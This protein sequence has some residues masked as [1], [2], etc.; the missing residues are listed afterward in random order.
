MKYSTH[1]PRPTCLSPPSVRLLIRAQ[2]IVRAVINETLRLFPPVPLNVRETRDAAVLLPPPDDTH[3]ADARPLYMPA[4]TTITYLPLLTQRNAALWGADAD[5]FDPTRWTDPARIARFVAQPTMFTPFSAGPRIVSALRPA[6]LTMTRDFDG[7]LCYSASG[8]T[9][10]TT[11][12]RTSSCGCCSSSTDS[13]SRRRYSL[14]PRCRPQTGRAAR[15]GRR[16]SASGR[17]RRSRCM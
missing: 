16:T 14:R 11:R 12:C 7:V 2:C 15:A 1:P 4:R 5:V 17:P 3:A 9:T 10:H 6:F 13:L 8:R